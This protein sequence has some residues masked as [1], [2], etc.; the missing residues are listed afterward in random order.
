MPA[1]MWKST[2]TSQ[3]PCFIHLHGGAASMGQHIYMRPWWV[4]EV[5]PYGVTVLSPAY[6]LAPLGNYDKQVTA[7][8]DLY[9]WTR[10]NLSGTARIVVGGTSWGGL[11]AMV[12]GQSVFPPPSAIVSMYGISQLRDYRFA[13]EQPD[14]LNEKNKLSGDNTEDEIRGITDK[15]IAESLRTSRSDNAPVFAN[16]STDLAEPGILQALGAT[17]KDALAKSA[18]LQTDI[19]KVA[20]RDGRFLEVAIGRAKLCSDKDWSQVLT[21]RS[22]WIRLSAASPPHLFIHGDHDRIVSHSQSHAAHDKLQALGVESH[23]IIVPGGDHGCDDDWKVSREMAPRVLVEL[24]SR[25]TECEQRSQAGRL[26]R[27][28]LEV[29]DGTTD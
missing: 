6:P 14:F 20:W 21:S 23:L 12:T 8:Q 3:G 4:E 26:I 7:C 28:W 5:V 27:Q 10:A 16:L 22:P 2:G 9:A 25:Q 1:R 18:R 13:Q 11:L 24:S 15:L 29:E 19:T 17:D